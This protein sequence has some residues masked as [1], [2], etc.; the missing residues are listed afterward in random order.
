MNENTENIKEKNSDLKNISINN[1]FNPNINTI[2]IEK[3]SVKSKFQDN[4]IINE[5]KDLNNP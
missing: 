2:N 5:K 4:E 3:I 1:S